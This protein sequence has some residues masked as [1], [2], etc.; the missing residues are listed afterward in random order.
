VFPY[1][2]VQWI[3]NFLLLICIKTGLRDFVQIY[4]VAPWEMPA[5]EITQVKR[6][7][8]TNIPDFYKNYIILNF[9][10]P[11]TLPRK[12]PYIKTGKS[13]LRDKM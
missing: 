12:F 4:G 10:T 1:A 7:K 11:S 9:Y 8:K 5:R 6:V 13:K 2:V 3:T